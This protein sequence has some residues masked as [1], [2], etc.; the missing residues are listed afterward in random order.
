MAEPPVLLLMLAAV[1][2]G[3]SKGGL[4][5]LAALAVPMLALVMNPVQAAALLLP[6]FLATDWAAVALYRRDWSGRNLAILVP[7]LAAGTVVA[8]PAAPAMPEAP[9][10]VFTGAVGLWT[11]LRSWLGRADAPPTRARVGPGLA[12][13]ALA[14]VTSFVTHSGAPP[15]QAFLL[16]QRLPRL[17]FA[18]TMAIA[19]AAGDVA[20][21]PGYWALGLLEGFDAG[22]MAL[23]LP[24]GVAGTAAG[25]WIV[26]RLRD[27]TYR[28]A[29]EAILFAF[30][31]LL[32]AQGGA[33]LLA[34]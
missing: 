22:L 6:V 2:V 27:D 3:L 31:V 12:W 10:L 18:G 1:V 9:L 23:L 7:A 11:C 26:R 25:R 17:V 20:K 33:G 24:A 29:V 5:F 15:A 4:A 32:I 8:V 28:R 16:P 34:A 19:F 14:G 30:S 13:G 21:L